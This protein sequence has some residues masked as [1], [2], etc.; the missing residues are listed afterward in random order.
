MTGHPAVV[1]RD[2]IFLTVKREQARRGKSSRVI[3]ISGHGE[4]KAGE[5]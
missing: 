2:N 1:F 4:T 3:F 5:R